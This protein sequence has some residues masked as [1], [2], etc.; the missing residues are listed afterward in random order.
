MS[1]AFIRSLGRGRQGF[2][3]WS[4]HAHVSKSCLRCAFV[5]YKSQESAQDGTTLKPLTG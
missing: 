2:Y 3:A 4:A 5:Y 1:W